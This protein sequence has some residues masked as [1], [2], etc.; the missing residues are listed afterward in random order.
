MLLGISVVGGVVPWLGF[1][2][3]RSFGVNAYYLHTVEE[4]PPL[5]ILLLAGLFTERRGVA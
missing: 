3:L 5:S 2:V 1:E 4:F